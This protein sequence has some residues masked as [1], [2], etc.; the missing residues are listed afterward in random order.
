VKQQE[1]SSWLV[2]QVP[3]R[4]LCN[5]GCFCTEMDSCGFS[6]KVGVLVDINEHNSDGDFYGVQFPGVSSIVYFWKHELFPVGKLATSQALKRY[7]LADVDVSAVLTK[8]GP[9][10]LVRPDA[11]DVEAD[12][13]NS[14]WEL[15]AYDPRV[16]RVII[17]GADKKALVGAREF[18]QQMMRIDPGT[19]VSAP[20]S[21]GF[22]MYSP[23][24][25]WCELEVVQ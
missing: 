16:R 2:L 13:V 11:Q 7:S 22:Y 23:E 18:A 15:S 8:R 5:C 21:I 6:N 4:T 3:V 20:I 19:P 25:K 9:M 24:I 14:E 10:R 1:N 12:P 17:F